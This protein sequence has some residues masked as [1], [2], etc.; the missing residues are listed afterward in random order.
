[1]NVLHITNAYPYPESRIFGIFVKEQI[2]SLDNYLVKND[3]YFINAKKKGKIEYFKSIFYLKDIV[4]KY[5]IIHT[6]HIFVG[7]IMLFFFKQIKHKIIVSLM[8]DSTRKGNSYFTNLLFKSSYKYCLKNASGVIFK[9]GIPDNMKRKNVYYLPNGVN[10][11]FFQE[12]PK[13]ECKKKLNLDLNRRYILFVSS[14]NLYRKEKRYDRFQEVIGILR[15]KYSLKDIEELLLVD[16]DRE[17]IPLYYNAADVNILVSDVEG[18][19]N[20]VKEAIACNT[21][22]VATNVGNIEK[23]LSG[24]NSCYVVNSFNSHE[25]ADRLYDCLR[26]DN[27]DVRKRI[28]EQKLDKNSTRQKLVFIYKQIMSK[29]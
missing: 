1:M 9:S 26:H 21:K 8:S 4:K 17:N 14:N 29:K 23:M 6:H 5:D 11:D 10:T 25:I 7:M 27:I 20:S 28:F 12:I 13:S 19:P 16:T 22:V 24:L 15:N 2:D 18:S 3:T